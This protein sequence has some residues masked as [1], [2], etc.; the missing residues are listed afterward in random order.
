MDDEA[1]HLLEYMIEPH[2]SVTS[3]LMLRHNLR[4]F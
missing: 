1:E 3:S 2:R 4:G